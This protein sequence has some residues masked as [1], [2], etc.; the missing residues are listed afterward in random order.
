MKR[1][2][3]SFLFLA[4]LA[5]LG[6]CQAG[7]CYGASNGQ[8]RILASTF[9]VY[10]FCA[11]ITKDAPDTSLEL[12]VPAAAGCP[13]DFAMRPADMLK[14]AKASVLV[15]NGAG[16]EDFLSKPLGSLPQPPA[17][18]DAA[19]NIPL[20][21]VQGPDGHDHDHGHYNSHIFAAPAQAR[22]M[23]LNIADGLSKLD[24]ANA[25]IYQAN[26]EKF[27]ASLE[28]L[29]KRFAAVGQ[30]AKNPRIALNHDALAYLAQDANLKI[31][32]VFENA[33]S[34]ATI[35][36]LKKRL[37]SEKPALLAGDS[38]YPARLLKT[39]ASETGIPFA[40]LDPCANGPENPPL[41]YYL[42]VME[43]NLKTLE[44]SFD[45]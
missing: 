23:V 21:P 28:N 32:A 1:L 22:L 36:G 4:G 19:A 37:T 33:D 42:R 13:H 6:V 43:A 9:P 8:F 26:A 35:A 30:K 17:I 5:V 16:L 11:N 34:A 38:Q 20:L 14:L 39:L 10:V 15:V 2:F 44:E 12:L 31:I 18:V 24:P 41:D 45:R 7:G 27:A 25:E 3:R 29:A 40:L